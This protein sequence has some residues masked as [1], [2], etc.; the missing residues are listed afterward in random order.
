MKFLIIWQGG[1]MNTITKFCLF[2]FITVQCIGLSHAKDSSSGCGP[3]WYILKKN[4]LVSSAL[5]A[6]TNNVLMPIVTIGMTIG[7]S[8]CSQH[9]IVKNEKRSIK[10]ATDNYFEI[11]ADAAKGNGEFLASFADTIGCSQSALPSF[12][13]KMK[14]NFKKIYNQSKVDPREMLKQTYI[15]I[16]SDQKLTQSCVLG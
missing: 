15:L 13:A 5:R 14:K 16:F 10:F 11:A 2:T 9:S 4:S 1:H 3:A 7:T 12:Q 8:N 6:T